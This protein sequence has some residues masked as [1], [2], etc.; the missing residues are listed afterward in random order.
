M[1]WTR[2]VDATGEDREAVTNLLPETAGGTERRLRA[3]SVR[4]F[5]YVVFRHQHKIVTFF[6]VVVGV[7]ALALV[8]TPDRYASEAKVLVR[9]GRESVALD[10]TVDSSK[11]IPVYKEWENDLNSELEILESRDLA[12]QV[13]R[14][15]GTQRILGSGSW[16]WWNPLDW[17]RGG[18]V[19]L[20]RLAGRGEDVDPAVVAGLVV[21]RGLVIDAKPKSNVIRIEYGAKESAVARDVVANLLD[22]YLEKHMAVHQAA[23]TYG[24]FVEQTEQ[25]RERMEEVEV[26]LRNLK[27]M[28]GIASIEEQ[29]RVLL[30]RITTLQADAEGAEA[31]IAASRAK[32]RALRSLLRGEGTGEES[33]R[34]VIRSSDY[35]AIQSKLLMEE[36]DLASVEAQA[37]TLKAQLS[38]TKRELEN[39]NDS[40]IRVRALEREQEILAAKYRKYQESMEQARIDRALET[41][42]ISNISVV[43]PATRPVRP[44]PSAK[45]LKMLLA[46]CVGL[47]GGVTLAFG[48]EYLTHTFGRPEDVE[49][50]LQLRALVSI[51]KLDASQVRLRRDGRRSGESGGETGWEVGEQSAR[52][53]EELRDRVL[54]SLPAPLGKPVILGVTSSCSGEGVTCV[55]AHLAAALAGRGRQGRV[56]YVNA[57]RENPETGDLLGIRK[58]PG[59]AE[60][61]LDERDNL[62]VMGQDLSDLGNGDSAAPPEARTT[63]PMRYDYLLPSLRKHDY[64]FVVLDLPSV[65]GGRA[66]VRLAGSTDGMILVLEADRVRWEVAER[67]KNLLLEADANVLGAVLNKRKFYVPQWLYRSL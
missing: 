43:Q 35:G 3:E 25:I 22:S 33:P 65:T 17:Y 63:V 16:S 5:Y 41:E 57:N 66:P 30:G 14:R 54:W 20:R 7:T 49:Q 47:C 44:S 18:R 39:L 11:V 6:G 19:L 1:A 15:V 12:E 24:F 28:F 46:I 56:L 48:C 31:Q 42:K 53:F 36:A 9:Q 10:P 52:W 32:V 62:K 4:D 13:A 45:G 37:E 26:A 23:G 67:A 21:R 60:V 27:N 8:F 38:E 2:R 40:E 50:V 59:A 55:A 34:T 64:S 61:M 51:P 58:A 29:Q